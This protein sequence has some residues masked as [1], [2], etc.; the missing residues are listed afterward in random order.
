MNAALLKQIQA[1]RDD[2]NV[3]EAPAVAKTKQTAATPKPLAPQAP[4]AKPPEPQQA[5]SPIPNIPYTPDANDVVVPD[6]T[7]YDEYGPTEDYPADGDM[8]MTPLEP[9]PNPDYD[10]EIEMHGN[11]TKKDKKSKKS[12]KSKKK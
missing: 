1:K 4:P 6:D 7:Y 5:H 10:M 12:K 9:T 8:H 3:C 2:D 11:T